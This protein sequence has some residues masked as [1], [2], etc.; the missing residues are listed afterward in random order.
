MFL[1][2]GCG[3]GLN[4]NMLTENDGLKAIGGIRIST[5]LPAGISF[6]NCIRSGPITAL[7]YIGPKMVIN[8]ECDQL[9]SDAK[10]LEQVKKYRA[11]KLVV[12]KFKQTNSGVIIVSGRE[13]KY[14]TGTQ[15]LI[16]TMPVLYGEFPAEKDKQLL[17]KVTGPVNEAAI[18]LDKT[19][20]FLRHIQ[21]TFSDGSTHTSDADGLDVIGVQ[22]KKPLPAGM[23]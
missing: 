7:Q 13:M 9:P 21:F 10:S 22:I 6:K 1:L 20:E 15:H 16:V 11:E 14:V 23:R 18:D 12:E 2:P 5:P 19:K 17:I 4:I 3:S 8:I